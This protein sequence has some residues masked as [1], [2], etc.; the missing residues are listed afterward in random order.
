MDQVNNE[1]TLPETFALAWVEFA[2]VSG[3]PELAECYMELALWFWI[4]GV[5]DCGSLVTGGKS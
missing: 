3:M 4:R 2:E 1:D 5:H